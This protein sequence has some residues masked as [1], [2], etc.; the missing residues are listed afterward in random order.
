[1]W[2]RRAPVARILVGAIA[3]IFLP[4]A[5]SCGDDSG[6]DPDPVPTK[7]NIIVTA[8]QTGAT[9]LL[10]G[11]A[12][13][14]TTDATLDELEPGTYV[15]R[16]ELD[17]YSVQPESLLVVVTAGESAIAQFVLTLLAQGSIAVTSSV[18]GG[19]ILFDGASTG[20]RTPAT[21]TGLN[22][23]S[24]SIDVILAGYES[25]GLAMR[26]TVVKDSTTDVAVTML[27]SAQGRIVMIEHFSN[28]SCT[29]CLAADTTLENSIEEFGF[30]TVSAIGIHT[31]N[32]ASTD[33]FFRE[34]PE[35]A[36][37]RAD[38]FA[39]IANPHVRIGGTQFTDAYTAPG[40]RSKINAAAAIEPAYNVAVTAVATAD[41]FVIT[42]SVRKRMETGGDEKLQV[43]LIETGIHF[44]ANNGVD[45]FDDITRRFLLGINGQTLNLSAGDVHTFRLSWPIGE[46]WVPENLEAV[47]FVESGSGQ[48]VFQ[49]G[50]TR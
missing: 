47:V 38:K 10:D 14:G 8:N 40:L 30:H 7:G 28:T 2:E 18:D 27:D 26:L 21:L 5:L 9:V 34:N 20:L 1:M 32:P 42:G 25:E 48:D 50:S 3:A 39:I 11:A 49:S 37:D 45:F 22:P 23:G 6:T 13:T 33:H 43:V 16:V 4:L 41:S 31:D 17:G 12:Q 29:P 36:L 46:T 19:A 44:D 15:I 35:Q 24:H